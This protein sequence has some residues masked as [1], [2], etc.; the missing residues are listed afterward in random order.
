M[1]RSSRSPCE[2]IIWY[3]LPDVRS[4]IAKY[5]INN[6]QLK[7]KEVSEILGITPAAVNQYLTSKRGGELLTLIKNKK[8]KKE[9]LADL[10]EAAVRIYEEKSPVFLEI[11]R[12]CNIIKDRRIINE[13]Y[14]KYENGNI[15]EWL[16][17]MQKDY[18]L[19]HNKIEKC[20]ECKTK[21]Q[22]DWIACPI[23]GKRLNK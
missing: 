6:Y 20:P 13:L 3:A 16:I 14:I 4:E 2:L 23:C 1:P 10:Q 22:Y 7:Q 21:L 15:P 19:K 12:I 5:L 8:M 9:F 11:C 18:A 17:Q